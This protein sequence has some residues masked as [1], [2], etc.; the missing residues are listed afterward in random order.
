MKLPGLLVLIPLV[1]IGNAGFSGAQSPKGVIE[2]Y[3][4]AVGDKAVKRVTATL[5]TGTVFKD[6]RAAGRFSYRASA[7]DRIRLD[8]ETE[9]GF[10]LCYNGKSAWLSDSRG[11][12]TL[13][14]REASSLRLFGLLANGRLRDLS[15]HRIYMR[16]ANP[17]SIEGRPA[18]AVELVMG[19]AQ[20]KLM[21][22]AE[23]NLLIKQERETGGGMEEISYADYQA[24]DGVMEPFRIT[25]RRPGFEAA[26]TIEHVE[27][28]R[29]IEKTAYSHPSIESG[30]PLPEIGA[31]MKAVVANQERIEELRDSYTYREVETERKLSGDGRVEESRTRIYQVTPVAGSFVRRLVNEDGRDL[32]PSE[33]EKEDRR[34]AKEVERA[35]KRQEEER[36]K[37][38]RA[39]DR[40]KKSDDDV[41]ILTFLRISEVSSVRREMFRG[42][43]V[44][45]FDFEPRKGLKAKNNAEKIASKLAGTAWVDE[46]GKQ[47]ARLEARL[48]D[49]YKIAGGLFA[50]VSPST[51]VVFEQ[52]KVDGELWLPSFAEA[53]IFA[54]VLLFANY[55]RSVTTR[56]SD[57]K[58]HHVDSDYKLEKPKTEKTH[59]KPRVP[60]LHSQGSEGLRL[61][62]P[63]NSRTCFPP[64]TRGVSLREVTRRS[65]TDTRRRDSGLAATSSFV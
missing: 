34:V 43:E 7:P 23:T 38:E 12:R 47:I 45:A 61:S 62:P 3:R 25:F 20:V 50:S 55:R 46:A 21:F 18:N 24:V 11:P 58:K 29:P 60:A 40:D 16:P 1:L 57:Y 8:L 42:Q 39:G 63:C 27:H 4:K 32:T 52:E 13:L 2:R 6:D 30:A 15:R 5:M 56:F 44:I 33:L 9:G 14:G 22:D 54:K 53:N 10:S 36:E 59:D 49:S 31:L 51:A 28:N 35:I 65:A 26:I 48:I 17:T 19:D 41:S 37:K 64:D